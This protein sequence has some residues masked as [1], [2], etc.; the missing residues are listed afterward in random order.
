M[1][2]YVFG[3]GSLLERAPRTR[4]NP[5]AVGA[6]P[7][8]VTGYQ[9]GW[10][11]NADKVGS[12]CTFLGA[13]RVKGQT[14][15][16][17]VYAVNDIEAT[18]RR[19]IGYTAV[20]LGA[21]DIMMLDGSGPLKIGADLQVYIFLSNPESISKDRE[22]TP[23]FPIVQSYVDICINGCL[24]LEALYRGVKGSFT[25]EFIRTT[26]GW[27]ANWVNDR[28]YPRRPFICA[29]TARAI[30]EALNAGNVLKYVHLCD[31]GVQMA[32]PQQ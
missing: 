30:D 1:A 28:I 6:W 9:R 14:I 2:S 5:E 3:Y 19:E 11:H 10:Y 31:P 20:A 26:S 4:T 29:P 18:K 8:R 17:V 32:M 21:D 22:P 15:N 16:G 24:E 23:K 7:A 13:E 12:S 27:N 25:Q